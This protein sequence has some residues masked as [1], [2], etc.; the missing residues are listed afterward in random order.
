LPPGELR[1][2]L[3][4]EEVQVIRIV[5]TKSFCLC[6]PGLL[7]A[8]FLLGSSA[9]PQSWRTVESVTDG[10]TL[11]LDNKEKVRLIGVDTPEL[12]DK[13]EPVAA[14]AKEARGFL[15][16]MA[17]GKRVRLEYDQNKTDMYG[18]TLAYLYLEDGTFVNAALVKSG[19]SQAYT[20]YPFKY[21]EEFRG[22]E[23]Q[24][25]A[26]G[27]GLWADGSNAV[28][29]QPTKT[30]APAAAKAKQQDQ[31]QIVYVSRTGTKYHRA[32]CRYLAK[33]SIPM[34][35][36]EAAARYG[37]CSICKPPVLSGK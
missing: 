28:A 12:T 26:G 10:D 3:T 14:M 31:E 6:F 21:L 32:G 19:Y 23:R 5:R 8:L 1:D 20:E 35:L 37:P 16:G 24:A 33:S 13:R 27:R 36:K 29:Q 25:R 11:V 9:I 22:Y 30:T 17:E 7:F 15:R 4:V 18:R 34:P 2:N